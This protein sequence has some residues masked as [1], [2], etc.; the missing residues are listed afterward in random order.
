LPELGAA[1][2]LGGAA[3]GAAD[4]GAA[5]AAFGTFDEGLFAANAADVAGAGALGADAAIG[6]ADLGAADAA[7]GAFDPGLFAENTASGALSPFGADVLSQGND[8]LALGADSGDFAAGPADLGPGPGPTDTGPDE[9]IVPSA[10]QPAP[11]ASTA[12]GAPTAPS[13]TPAGFAAT[14]AELSGGIT[15]AG[16]TAPGGGV[17]GTIS[18]LVQGAGGWGNIAKWGL[19]GAPL[20]LTLARGEAGLP[21]S[22]QQ[23][24]GQAG[25]L[26]Q[27]GLTDLSNARAGI[28]NAGQTAV[29]GQMR[30]DLTNQ[31]RQTLYN[32]GVKDITKDARWPQI[33]AVI[34]SQVTQQTATMIQQNITNALAETG[35]ASQALIAIAN[36]QMQADTAFTNNLVNA[37]KSL[38]LMAALSGGNTKVTQ[39]IAA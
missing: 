4:L 31:W 10:A 11:V 26:S 33:E 29:L 13:S 7:F 8:V 15:G 3:E 28:L 17:G 18:S 9:G 30:A 22:A 6:A 37:T 34:D 12:I 38:G 35:Q 36:M 2:G 27:A 20:A 39:T 24:Q 25:V 23:L 16:G 5:N 32:Q 1:I 19:A 21:S 14:D